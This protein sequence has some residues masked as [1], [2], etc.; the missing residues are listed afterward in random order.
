MATLAEVCGDSAFRTWIESVLRATGEAEIASYGLG[1][2][3]EPKRVWVVTNLALHNFVCAPDKTKADKWRA[4]GTSRP[5]SQIQ[6]V[7]IVWAGDPAAGSYTIKATVGIPPAPPND[8]TRSA[9]LL[10]LL[11]EC[12][13][14]QGRG[15]EPVA[16]P[17]GVFPNASASHANG[18][19]NGH[20]NG[21]SNGANGTTAVWSSTQA[22]I[23]PRPLITKLVVRRP[24]DD[25]TETGDRVP[26]LVPSGD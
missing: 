17:V 22:V 23:A 26:E 10:G 7:G 5:W 8:P 2:D 9:A 12:L 4:S 6:G 13:R 21:K 15:P 11:I 24:T 16:E 20:P 19:G 18:N 1:A 3:D 25:L 14:R